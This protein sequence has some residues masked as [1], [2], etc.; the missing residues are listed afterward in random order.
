MTCG[1]RVAAFTMLV[2]SSG[3]APGG[4]E[5]LQI[6]AAASLREALLE[7]A[8]GCEGAAEPPFVFNF[9]ASND[10][11]RQ[12]RAG[13]NADLF[14]SADTTQMDAL[15]DAN[16][17]E[18]GTRAE[19][20]SNRLVVVAPADASMTYT[21]ISSLTGPEI[22]RL[23]IANPDAVP[24]GKYAR[25]WLEA[26]GAWEAVRD[27]V[28]PGVDVRAAL[29]AVES[30]GAEAG[31]VYVTDAALTTKVRVVHEVP[32]DEGPRISY[33]AAVI[34]GQSNVRRARAALECLV[35]PARRSVYESHGFIVTS[36]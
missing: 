31:I 3:C 13:A 7:A 27:R 5:P 17:L 15:A 34:A 36:R 32:L 23:S 11:A 26:A 1:S 9:G 29:A 33:V 8:A 21:G 35:S 25:A 24:A 18:P 22:R 28:L 10:L 14:I 12:I 30:G 20:L 4:P 6:C 16:L 19:F 2:V